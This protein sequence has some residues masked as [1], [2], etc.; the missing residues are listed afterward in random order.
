M[1]LKAGIIV[2]LGSIG[3]RHLRYLESCQPK[4]QIDVVTRSGQAGKSGITYDTIFDINPRDY[5]FAIVAN[6]ASAHVDTAEYFL[7]H[8]VPVLIEKPLDACMTKACKLSLHP[9]AG[10]ALLGYSLRFSDLYKHLMLRLADL[11]SVEHVSISSRSFLPDWRKGSDYRESVSARKELGGGVLLEISHEID[12]AIKIIGGVESAMGFKKSSKILGLE[13][14]DIADLV[15]RN[16]Q[17][18]AHVHLNMCSELLSRT[19][20]VLTENGTL[21]YDFLDQTIE[22]SDGQGGI[23]KEVYKGPKDWIKKMYMNEVSHFLDVVRFMAEPCVTLTDGVQVLK[24][25]QQAFGGLK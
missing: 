2:G 7:N 15:I 12:L 11:G 22:I 8:Q 23:L 25:I 5:D 4:L 9:H 10:R 6:A 18:L 13:V 14:E 20:T 3:Q 19:G 24:A 16:G 1:P 21:R 17:H